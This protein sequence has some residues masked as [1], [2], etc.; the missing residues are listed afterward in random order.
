MPADTVA[1]EWAFV[2]VLKN[3]QNWVEAEPGVGGQP[4]DK[5]RCNYCK[6][7]E[8]ACQLS[9]VR[10][11]IAAATGGLQGGGQLPAVGAQCGVQAPLQSI[12]C[13]FA[14]ARWSPNIW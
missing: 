4:G 11:H 13:S 3:I 14:L 2:T 5:C 6:K 9:R 12:C 7:K 1:R 10:A 8:F